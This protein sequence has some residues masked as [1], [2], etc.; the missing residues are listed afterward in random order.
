MLLHCIKYLVVLLF[1]IC[2][3]NCVTISVAAR[4]NTT[5][6]PLLEEVSHESLSQQYEVLTQEINRLRNLDFQCGHLRYRMDGI[7][8]NLVYWGK[9]LLDINNSEA[10]IFSKITVDRMLDYLESILN[11]R[12]YDDGDEN[13]RFE[14]KL[15]S[16]KQGCRKCALSVNLDLVPFDFDVHQ[17]ISPF[18]IG[19]LDATVNCIGDFHLTLDILSTDDEF[20][21]VFRAL[22]IIK[23]GRKNE[24]LELI[25]QL[26]TNART[27][28]EVTK[29][30]TSD[31]LKQISNYQKE[32]K[33]QICQL[34]AD[35]I[36]CM[37]A[38][39]NLQTVTRN[40]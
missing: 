4:F 11:A 10:D 5:E 12:Y 18:Y 40:P 28:F 25:D 7:E 2:I 35:K 36:S 37:D 13:I 3:Q 27:K 19:K 39:A 34:K 17:P 32:L 14:G 38:L 21:N 23:T 8:S 26:L 33:L 16:G 1:F 6:A 24:Y 9:C 30:K 20:E 15:F 22:M 29:Q 31:Y